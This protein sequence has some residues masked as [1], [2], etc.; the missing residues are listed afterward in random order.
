[1]K[2][3]NIFAAAAGLVAGYFLFKKDDSAIGFTTSDVHTQVTEDGTVYKHIHIADGKKKYSVML[4]SGKHNYVNVND[5]EARKRWTSLGKDFRNFDEAV[6]HY[7]S[8]GMKAML[9]WAED[10]LRGI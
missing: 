8:P 10:K 9:L 1:M 3:Q 6:Q 5:I 4:V 7:K 2:P